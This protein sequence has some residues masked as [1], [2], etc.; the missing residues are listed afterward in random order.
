MSEQ[1]CV[2]V[3]GIGETASAIARRV[4]AEDRAVAIHQPTP[5]RTLRRRM[6]FSDAWY[7]G[8]TS[9]DGVEA[10]RADLSSE[11]LLGLQ[12]RQFIPILT[13]RFSDVIERW[14]WDV[15][16]A[17]RMDEVASIEDIKNCADLTIG[18]GAGFIAGTD[19]DIVIETE[20]SDPGAIIRSGSVPK[21]GV[22][23]MRDDTAN[24]YDISAPTSGL[25]QPSKIIGA[26]VEAG[27]ALGAIGDS[28]VQASAS[29]RIKGLVRKGQA[30]LAGSMIGEIITSN[31]APVAGVS[32][33]NQL[34]SRGVSFAI[35]AESCGWTPF[36]FETWR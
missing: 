11:F 3:C 10:R 23:G 6:A 34:I 28:V 26:F 13:Q 19:C 12:T 36:S 22:R 20:G 9:L 16:V 8:A 29:G 17:S 14:P 31:A 32:R 7:D 33:R 2:L 5:P 4:F 15:I 25:F 1:I 35:E 27:E 30:V 24:R 18:L 21:R